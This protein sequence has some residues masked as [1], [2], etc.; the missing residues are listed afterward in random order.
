MKKVVKKLV[1]EYIGLIL[2]VAVL[3]GG[4]YFLNKNVNNI[5][6]GAKINET[7]N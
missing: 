1:R 6:E 2:F 7:R 4:M 3:V 5:N